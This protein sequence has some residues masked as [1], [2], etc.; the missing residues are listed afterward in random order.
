VKAAL[1]RW[2]GDRQDGRIDDEHH[3]TGRDNAERQPAAAVKP[4]GTSG[5]ARRDAG[6]FSH[7]SAALARFA[8]V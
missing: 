3:L 6:P 4:P 5:A 8:Q 7:R 2:H 1:D